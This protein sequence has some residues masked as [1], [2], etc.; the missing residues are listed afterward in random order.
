MVPVSDAEL[1]TLASSYDIISLGMHADEARRQRH[2]ARTT[3]VRVARVD[4]LP[5]APIP[6]PDTAGELRIV[7]R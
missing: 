6:L 7:D 2:G 4:A 3:F 5:G 1:S